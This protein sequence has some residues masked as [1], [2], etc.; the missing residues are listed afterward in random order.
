MLLTG[1]VL[2]EAGQALIALGVGGEDGDVGHGG[3]SNLLL[4]LLPGR[5]G[6]SGEGPLA[7]ERIP[8]H[9]LRLFSTK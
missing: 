9:P 8:L 5:R 4:T 3:F 1:D 6:V 7:A 2:E